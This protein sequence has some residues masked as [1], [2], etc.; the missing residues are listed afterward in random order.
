VKVAVVGQVE[1][2]LAQ[3]ARVAV[4]PVGPVIHRVQRDALGAHVAQCLDHAV[5][6]HVKRGFV[7]IADALADIPDLIRRR[8]LAMDPVGADL[9][10]CVGTVVGHA[11]DEFLEQVEV[12][13][14]LRQFVRVTGY[15]Q[16]A[17]VRADVIRA[18]AQEVARRRVEVV[19]RRGETHL[20]GKKLVPRIFPALRF[21]DSAPLV[22]LSGRT[23]YIA[24]QSTDQAF[25]THAFKPDFGSG[26]LTRPATG[27]KKARPDDLA[28]K[29]LCLTKECR[30]IGKL[31]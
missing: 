16:H 11:F 6:S 10:A 19:W 12:I 13:D 23:I 15:V 7:G 20:V 4:A 8:A 29:I 21:H 2:G 26:D 1:S 17:P 30:S 18:D 27:I 25:L 14:A 28:L 3:K 31:G 24:S 9:A 5:A 22:W